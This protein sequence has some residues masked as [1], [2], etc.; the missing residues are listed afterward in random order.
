MHEQRHKRHFLLR[1]VLERM[2]A[3]NRKWLKMFRLFPCV[4][5]H[6]GTLPRPLPSSRHPRCLSVVLFGCSNTYKYGVGLFL[7]PSEPQRN[8][9]WNHFVSTSRKDWVVNTANS[10]ICSAH[11]E[12]EDFVHHEVAASLVFSEVT[13]HVCGFIDQHTECWFWH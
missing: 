9:A 4:W 1:F 5:R 13:L 2:L 8:R 12:E 6:G 3:S 10:T 11:F 7:F